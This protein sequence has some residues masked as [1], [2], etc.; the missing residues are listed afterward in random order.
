MKRRAPELKAHPAYAAA[1]AQ[2]MKRVEAALGPGKPARPVVA[3]I[4]GGA[5]LHFYTGGRISSDV[6]ASLD[7]R[8][9]LDAADLRVAY[10]LPD[11]GPQM[12]YYDT[13]YNESF[14][15]MHED[16]KADA[17]PVQVQGVDP[18]RLQVRLLTP[19]DLAVSKLSR[20]SEQDREDIRALAK[21]GL[22]TEAA[23]RRRA[24]EALPNY[25]GNLA[26]I[27][28]C[29]DI[30]CKDMAGLRSRRGKK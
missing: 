30:A 13:Q 23:L 7:A 1:F 2:V 11:G 18:R 21:Q 19:V 16:A 9:L 10:E 5:A 8:V 28:N 22:V 14:A 3:A 26:R 4:A 17:L 6:D 29:V 24:A 15:L 25:V 12:L 27:R 20:F